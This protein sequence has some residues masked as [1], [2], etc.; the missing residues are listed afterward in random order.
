MRLV[1]LKRLFGRKKQQKNVVVLRRPMG[2]GLDKDYSLHTYRASYMN[3]GYG[4]RDIIFHASERLVTYESW[5]KYEGEEEIRE[6]YEV[7]IPDWIT[8]KHEVNKY[9]QEQCKDW[10]SYIDGVCNIYCDYCQKYLSL[11]T[12]K[13]YN[14]K[15]GHSIC[16]HCT[17][18][19]L[20]NENISESDIQ[21]ITDFT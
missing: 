2:I 17:Q 9:V 8:T 12:T 13:F 20:L 10:P 15:T 3:G 1:F 14:L 7:K 6:E 18:S 19:L 21:S 16:E 11:Y 5:T 4:G